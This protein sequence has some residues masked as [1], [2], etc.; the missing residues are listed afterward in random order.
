VSTSPPTCSAAAGLS[1][2]AL[3][4]NILRTAFSCVRDS[5]AWPL[6]LFPAGQ[7]GLPGWLLLLLV[8]KLLAPA[9]MPARPLGLSTTADGAAAAADGVIGGAVSLMLGALPTP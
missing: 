3:I 2:G 8:A 6:G 7:R 4:G 1:E 5:S 9:M